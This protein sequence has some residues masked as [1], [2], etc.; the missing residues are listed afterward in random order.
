M[1]D[2]AQAFAWARMFSG[3]AR[4]ESVLAAARDTFDP[5]RPCAICCAVCRAR[6]AAGRQ[7]PVAPSQV[8]EKIVLILDRPVPFV[9]ASAPRAWPTMPV[10]RAQVRVADVPV[11]PP[12]VG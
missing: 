4:T 1:L 9:P 3:Y 7:A 8:R 2:V 5:A 6:E 10:G 11:P 12:R